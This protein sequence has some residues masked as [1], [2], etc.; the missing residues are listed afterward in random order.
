MDMMKHIAAMGIWLRL[1]IEAKR[2]PT[3][4]FSDDFDHHHD[5]LFCPVAVLL[6][7]DIPA[8]LRPAF[9]TFQT[10]REIRQVIETQPVPRVATGYLKADRMW[11]AESGSKMCGY[12][13]FHSVTAHWR[14]PDGTLG[15][16]RLENEMPVDAVADAKGI[17]LVATN[18]AKPARLIWHIAA[19]EPR[20]F[21]KE[22]WQLPG[23]LVRLKTDLTAAAPFLGEAGTQVVAYTLAPGQT[24]SF[25]FEFLSANSSR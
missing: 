19:G 16:I 5:F 9:D 18:G 6:G 15:W 3:P 14:Q 4:S 13:Q 8:E 21:G 11:G 1:E 2:A 22:E 12:V 23:M 10:E 17:R 25:E 20:T 7:M 24:D